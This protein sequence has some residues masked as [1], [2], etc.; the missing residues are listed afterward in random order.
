LSWLIDALLA[1]CRLTADGVPS[2]RLGERPAPIGQRPT[3]LSLLIQ[4]ELILDCPGQR[5]LAEQG[6]ADQPPELFPRIADQGNVGLVLI[7]GSDE[8][9]ADHAVGAHFLN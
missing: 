7:S 3:F 8:S 6:L 2:H 5:H 9:S 4:P 1:P